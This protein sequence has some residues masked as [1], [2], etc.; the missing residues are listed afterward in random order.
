MLTSSWRLQQQESLIRDVLDGHARGDKLPDSVLTTLLQDP[1]INDVSLASLHQEAKSVNGAGSETTSRALT[2][3]TFHILDRPSVRSTL[4]SELQSAIPDANAEVT[5]DELA[6]L[7]Y[8]SACVDEALRLSYGVIERRARAYDGGPLTYTDSDTG[9]SWTIPRGT[10]VSM[11]NYDVSHD[12]QIFPESYS[13]V[14]ERWLGS[15]RAPDGRQLSRY[16]ASF[17][18]G[19][20]DCLG[21]QLAYLE[22]SLGLAAFFRAPCVRRLR[23]GDCSKRDVMMTRDCFV[24]RAPKDSTGVKAVFEAET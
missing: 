14:P 8:L 23:L 22:L 18:K 11:D 12:E 3:A 4:V 19:R 5:W 16:M 10:F 2:V 9:Q 21:K 6:Q 20:R 24:P 13:F 7:P 17:G 15:P 1:N